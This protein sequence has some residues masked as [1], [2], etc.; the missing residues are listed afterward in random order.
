M[1][2]RDSYTIARRQCAKSTK[3][4]QVPRP[5][6]RKAFKSASSPAVEKNSS[7]DNSIDSDDSDDD[8]DD[9]D[10][11][12]YSTDSDDAVVSGATNVSTEISIAIFRPIS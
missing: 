9:D 8:D 6:Q 5:Q 4:P 1:C 3:L 2:I 10:D 11:E 7:C 12:S